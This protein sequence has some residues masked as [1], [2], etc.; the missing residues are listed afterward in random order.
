M[1]LGCRDHAASAWRCP[2]R[3]AD[4]R[5]PPPPWHRL[6]EPRL[7]AR[8][9]QR[10]TCGRTCPRAVRPTR[11]DSPGSRRYCLHTLPPPTQVACWDPRALLLCGAQARTARRPSCAELMEPLTGPP[12]RGT[13]PLLCPSPFIGLPH[14]CLPHHADGMIQCL[15][16]AAPP[17]TPPRQTVE[18]PNRGRPSGRSVS[19]GCPRRSGG[20]LHVHLVRGCVD[21]RDEGSQARRSGQ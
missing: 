7:A 3:P 9:A 14:S 2:S 11:S 16:P 13:Q 20:V 15:L 10:P 4:R 8:Q 5:Q 18:A 1:C 21:P 19:A 12:L 6:R 17:P